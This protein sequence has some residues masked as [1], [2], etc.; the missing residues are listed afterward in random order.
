MVRQLAEREHPGPFGTPVR[1]ARATMDRWITAWRRGGFDALVPSPRQ[2][3][4]R[5]PAEIL[6]MAAA[7]KRENPGRTAAQVAPIL[8]KHLGWAPSES[9]VL[10]HLNRLEL[11]GPAPQTVVFGRFEADRPNELWVGDALCRWR[12][13]ASYEDWRVMPTNRRSRAISAGGEGFGSPVR[14]A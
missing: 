2:A 9:T 14:V 12:R 1:V 13:K 5:T 7:L 11:I 8:H 3:T 10:R 6:D 4:P